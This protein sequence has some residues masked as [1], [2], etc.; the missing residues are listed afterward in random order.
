MTEIWLAFLAGLT[1]S[2]HCIG[3][4]GGIVAALSMTT[5]PGSARSRTIS[6]ALYNIG[7]ITTYTFLGVVA[8]FIGASLDLP[9]MRAVGVWLGLAANIMV[10]AIGLASALG[11]SWGLNSLES[12]SGRFFAEPLRKAISGDSTLAFL[13]IGLMLG[14]LPCGLIYGP[15]AVAAANGRPLRGGMMMLA[16]G[17]GTVPMLMIFGSATGTVSAVFRNIMFRVLGVI[18]A[19]I[20]LM[21]LLRVLK[22]MGMIYGFSLW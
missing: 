13:P 6:L 7:R 3:M 16:L 4:C 14:F 11:F 2:F 10:I 18:I 9:T 12:S 5:R 20:G 15:L 17:L 19:A 22:R 1:G 21:G 8:G